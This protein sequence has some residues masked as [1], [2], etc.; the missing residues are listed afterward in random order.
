MKRVL[1]AVGP[2]LGLVGCVL[3]DEQAFL[4]ERSRSCGVAF[5]CPAG[6]SCVQGFCVPGG[7]GGDTLPFSLT[8]TVPPADVG[9]V[10][11]GTTYEDPFL[12][13]AWRRDQVLPVEVRLNGSP[14]A[15][16]PLVAVLRS[17]V[18]SGAEVS[19][20]PFPQGQPCDA[21]FC[22]GAGLKLWEP[23]FP[24][25]RG[26]MTVEVRALDGGQDAGG[27]SARV[28]V[29]RWKWRHDLEAPNRVIAAPA[30]GHSGVLY[31]GTTNT[32]NDDGRF[33][34]L[35]PEGRVA[36]SSS[37][38]AVVA[39]PTVGELRDG[40]TER[41]YVAHRK[42]SASRVGFYAS[43]DG[44]FT[45]TCPD[46]LGS[47]VRVESSLALTQRS[48][49]G[50][51][52]ETVYGVYSGSD[53]GG[54]LFAMRPDAPSDVVLQCPTEPGVG[55]VSLPGNMLA[56]QG[57]VVFA[58]R[59]G[60][61]K[62]YS[63]DST[64]RGFGSRWSTPLSTSIF[65]VANPTSLAV[66][67]RTV[68]GG[69]NF[70]GSSGSLFGRLFSA[71]LDAGQPLEFSRQAFSTLWN[72]SIGGSTEARAV[73]G[74][75]ESALFVQ[76]LVDGGVESFVPSPEPTRGA[77]VWGAGGH[78]YTAGATTGLI[79]AFE[80]L[81]AF[82]PVLWRFE[83]WAPIEASMNL[84]CAREPDGG[85]APG[86]PGVLYAVTR[87]GNV[88]ALI[89]DSPGLD[90]TAPWPRYQHDARNTGNPVTRLT[91]CP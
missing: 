37:G 1:W 35:F 47:T 57:A 88:H 22:G 38:G 34:A 31:V 15:P 26:P 44:R 60:R 58:T 9:G 81:D 39:S 33:V 43:A 11:G 90:T 29:T 42:G 45:Q 4:E 20:L 21:G 46:V 50:V 91:P 74:L 32:N 13:G 82:G 63:L 84:D 89:V 17:E 16:G 12:P 2:L 71:P 69:G 72:V 77:P 48:V 67:G 24:A 86:R 52:S 28:N 18:G 6:S 83:P 49:S 10:S 61:L 40:G 51:S 75:D 56:A 68:V 23:P 78:V 54:T 3:P 76:P 65:S 36:W 73:V 80:S 53:D 79:Q 25:F 27:V 55:D 64:G 8:V 5:A 14:L 87:S 30:L 66:V 19:V 59:D 7:D 85:V 62:S 41:V 70:S